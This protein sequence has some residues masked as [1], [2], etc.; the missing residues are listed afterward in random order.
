MTRQTWYKY[1]CPAC[2]VLICTN[3]QDKLDKAINRHLKVCKGGHNGTKQCKGSA[4]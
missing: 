1:R 2:K 4:V 3:S